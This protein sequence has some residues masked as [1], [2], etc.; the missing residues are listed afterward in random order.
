M[1]ESVLLVYKCKIKNLKGKILMFFAV[2]LPQI[3]GDMICPLTGAQLQYLFPKVEEVESLCVQ[4]PVDYLIGSD[5]AGSQ[6]IREHKAKG[7]GEF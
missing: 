7:D 5:E 6:P 3:T 4:D 2:A 1:E